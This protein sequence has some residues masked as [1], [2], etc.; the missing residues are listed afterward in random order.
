LGRLVLE[1]KTFAADGATRTL[2]IDKIPVGLYF[3]RLIGK[4]FS[5]TLTVVKQ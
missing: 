2:Q 5:K 4:D 3:V 1:D